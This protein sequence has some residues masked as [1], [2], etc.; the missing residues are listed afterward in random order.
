MRKLVIALAVGASVALGGCATSPSG[1]P[2]I[3]PSIQTQIQN[4]TAAAC[5][6]VPT[7][8]T[9]ASILA[10]FV[11]GGPIVGVVGSTI[12]AICDAVAPPKASLKRKFGKPMV[13]GVPVE[14]YFIR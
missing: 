7:I 5:G 8:T 1:Q 9:V 11:G 4:G 13:N 12:K 3:D 14:G 10:S 6:F 2:T